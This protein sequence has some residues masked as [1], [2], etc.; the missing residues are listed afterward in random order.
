MTNIHNIFV[1]VI[2]LMQ[3]CKKMDL[4]KAT[5]TDIPAMMELY[6]QAQASLKALGV[7]QWQ[8]NYPNVDVVN[9]DLANGA[10]YVLTIG[11]A[12]IAAATIIFNH[13]PTYDRIYEGE[14]LSRGEFVVVHR[15]A[16]D[17]RYKMKGV[18]SHVLDEVEK[19]AV[20]ANIPSFKI[21]THKDN[22]PM[23]KTL[24]KNGFTCCGRIVLLDGN[25]RVAFEKILI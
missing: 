8:N 19:M 5:F 1:Y 25:S 4:R 18:A 9:K 13:E 11:G 7:D 21:D 16:V 3:Y 12:V 17:N 20:R 24:Q 6:V 22:L 14:W 23:R 2:S 10:A 15:L